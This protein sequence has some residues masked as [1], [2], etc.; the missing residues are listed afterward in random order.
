M[1]IYCALKERIFMEIIA[2]IIIGGFI[3]FLIITFAV[4]IAIKESLYEFKEDVYKGFEPNKSGEITAKD[5]EYGLVR[6]RDIEVLCNTEL[7]EVIELYQNKSIRKEDYE[8]Y[9]K[10]AKVLNELKE[11]DYFTEEQLSSKMDKLKKH[12]KMD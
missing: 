9:Q 7:E 10:Y 12:F 5:K 6:L 8:Q 2:M 4:K 1:F 3:S 11:M